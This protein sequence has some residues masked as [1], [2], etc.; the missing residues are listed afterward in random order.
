MLH[1]NFKPII[2]QQEDPNE[3]ERSVWVRMHSWEGAITVATFR[4][5]P[6]MDTPLWQSMTS[7]DFDPC[8]DNESK[9]TY[10]DEHMNPEIKDGREL[11][12]VESID[13][14]KPRTQ[15]E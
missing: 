9:I 4:E 10:W 11:I 7:F 8:Y 5:K 15:E 12:L 14:C 3:P 13:V 2:F 1:D 6:T